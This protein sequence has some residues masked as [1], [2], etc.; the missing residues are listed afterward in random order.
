MNQKERRIYLIQQLLKEA[1][2]Y[3]N[4]EIPKEE[5]AQK[6]LLRSLLNVRAPYPVEPEFLKIQDVYLSEEIRRKGIVEAGS[7]EPVRPG[8][9]LYLWQGDI[10]RLNADA[11]VNAA[12]SAML[13]CFQ[14]CHSCIDNIIHTMAGVQLRQ[15]CSELMQAQG[16]EEPA[17]QAKITPG[18]NLPCRYVLHTV[19]P[20]ISGALRQKDCEVLAGCYQ[21]CLETAVENGCR[22]IAF[23]CISTGVFHFPQKEAAEIAA[24][25]VTRFLEKND[26]IQQ[27]IFDVFTDED[28]RIYEKVLVCYS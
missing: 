5:P 1:K 20:V 3:Q 26:F 19:G 27:V 13:G 12:N 15:K 22:S 11:I 23:C 25:T 8:S 17:G 14:P 6:Q 7:L 9:R 24:E 10:T 4:I 2:Q 21:S 16:H 28:R 18:Y